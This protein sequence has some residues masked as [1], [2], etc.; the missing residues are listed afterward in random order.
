MD[1]RIAF[2]NTFLTSPVQN[3]LFYKSGLKDGCFQKPVQPDNVFNRIHL[4]PFIT[5]RITFR[6]P[7]IPFHTLLPE[8]NVV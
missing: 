8:H 4:Q 3:C 1:L 7:L 5:S 6:S 2:K